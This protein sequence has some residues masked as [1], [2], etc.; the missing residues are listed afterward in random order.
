MEHLGK[1]A[2]GVALWHL[3][4]LSSLGLTSGVYA[5]SRWFL[6]RTILL[7]RYHQAGVLAACFAILAPVVGD[8]AGSLATGMVIAALLGALDTYLIYRAVKQC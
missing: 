7:S 1:W 2:F 3:G 4:T 8:R 6:P 5:R